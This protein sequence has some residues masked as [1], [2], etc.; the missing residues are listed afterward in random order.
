MRSVW[1]Q[2]VRLP[3]RRP[4]SAESCRPY[5]A[6]RPR[7]FRVRLA[8]K[9]QPGGIRAHRRCVGLLILAAAAKQ[10]GPGALLF[11]PATAPATAAGDAPR[12]A[13][14]QGRRGCAAPHPGRS[15]LPHHTRG[16]LKMKAPPTT[17]LPTAYCP[18]TQ[19]C[20]WGMLLVR[21]LSAC[22]SAVAALL[23]N[24][25]RLTAT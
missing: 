21:L 1:A 4:D 6:Q 23:A 2:R 12:L 13:A 5:C 18:V 7:R 22:I 25:P 15:Y 24:A 17:K 8:A 19:T 9:P 16:A 11:I 3:L 14:Q 20:S 10:H